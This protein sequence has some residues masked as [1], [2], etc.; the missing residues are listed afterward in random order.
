MVTWSSEAI[1]QLILGMNP[2]KEGLTRLELTTISSMFG[3]IKRV[4]ER[5]LGGH[6]FGVEIRHREI[7]A[8]SDGQVVSKIWRASPPLLLSSIKSARAVRKWVAIGQDK[9]G[10]TPRRKRKVRQAR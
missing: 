9:V 6:G 4:K 1:E 2:F 3:Q 8:T 5:G 7:P 10:R